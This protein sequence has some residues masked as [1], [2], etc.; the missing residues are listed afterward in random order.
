MSVGTLL[1][2]SENVED[3]DWLHLTEG[4]TVEW[5]GRPSAYTIAT[6]IVVG[7]VLAA[8]GIGLAI[9][10]STMDLPPWAAALPLVLVVVGIGRILMAYLDWVRLLYVITSE[11]IYVKHGLVSRDVTQ[12]RLD[13]IQNTAYDQSV[14]E[15]FL[16]FGD[17]R[18]YT[19]GTSTEDVTFRDVPDPQRVKRTLTN[20][21]SEQGRREP[22]EL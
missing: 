3:A 2:G 6:S 22:G 21:L 18:V 9:W 1:P 11:E 12:I 20:L 17:V 8:V 16:S 7:V 14:A 13:R 15:R 4:E 5:V 10:L 19:A